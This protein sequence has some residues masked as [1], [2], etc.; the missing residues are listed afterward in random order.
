MRIDTVVLRRHVDQI[1]GSN[2]SFSFNVS[3]C[4]LEVSLV[5]KSEVGDRLRGGGGSGASFSKDSGPRPTP[6]GNIKYRNEATSQAELEAA[7]SCQ[8]KDTVEH[9]ICVR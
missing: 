7:Y 8:I 2:P 4:Q 1:D 6:R 3:K 9:S 5:S